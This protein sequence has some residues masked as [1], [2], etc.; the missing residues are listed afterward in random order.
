M[1]QM[2]GAV[3]PLAKILF[4]TIEKA[5]PDKDLQV[6]LK[7]ELQTQL[8]QSHTQELQAAARIVEAEA[9]AGWFASSWRPLLM[10]VLIFILVWNYVIGPVIKVFTGAI[11]SFERT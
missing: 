3:A 2:L 5:V 9:K 10:Y 7:A 11:I 8:L 1:L 4:N 6:K